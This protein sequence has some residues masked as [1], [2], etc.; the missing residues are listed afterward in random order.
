M[1]GN[2]PANNNPVDLLT[3]V[4][5]ESKRSFFGQLLYDIYYGH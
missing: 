3:K 5:Y 4:L 2:I 1:T